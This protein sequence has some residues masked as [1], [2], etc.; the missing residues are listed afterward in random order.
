VLYGNEGLGKDLTKN[1]G[2]VHE[3]PDTLM[4]YIILEKDWKFPSRFVS[5]GTDRDFRTIY[6]MTKAILLRW[7]F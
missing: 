1:E 5:V 4:D 2:K 6:R 7:L 3:L